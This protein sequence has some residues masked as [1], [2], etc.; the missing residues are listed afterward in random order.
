MSESI[1]FRLVFAAL[2]LGGAVIA[3]AGGGA[4]R[5]QV[6]RTVTHAIVCL[7][8]ATGYFALMAGQRVA[9]IGPVEIA[10][11]SL[12][13]FFVIPLLVLAVAVT[14]APLGRSIVPMTL[15]AMFLGAVSALAGAVA[16][17]TVG[18]SIWVW[19]GVW[20][21]T[22]GL[23]FG[24]LWQPMAEQAASGHPLRNEIYRRHAGVLTVLLALYPVAFLL[25]PDMLGAYTRPSFD[26]VIGFLDVVLMA[27]YGLLVV[28]EDERLV[29]L[30]Q[31]AERLG[32]GG[33]ELIDSPD[34][35]TAPNAIGGRRL[36]Q[37]HFESEAVA[38]MIRARARADRTRAL[39]GPAARRLAQ[40]AKDP[41]GI[42]PNPA[43]RQPLLP[44][45]L[46]RRRADRAKGPFDFTTREAV[47]VT[48]VAIT[49]FVIANAGRN[50]R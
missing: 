16:D 49:L 18:A 31:A 41:L 46:R 23:T 26:A 8:G 33:A 40:I 20:L 27:G 32:E 12:A 11:R 43:R 10:T 42:G 1:T 38:A 6:F 5:R 44:A 50:R 47:P 9:E 29:E 28:F 13:W 34:A 2:V 35:G 17:E 4:S 15:T 3:M 21:V 14:A 24:V 39:S 25:G 45:P 7:V 37:Y 36:D 48:V 22:L 19:F 30:E